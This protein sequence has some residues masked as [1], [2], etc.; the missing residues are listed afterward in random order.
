[1]V[2][3][4]YQRRGMCWRVCTVSLLLSSIPHDGLGRISE[5]DLQACVHGITSPSTQMRVVAYLTC[6][7]GNGGVSSGAPL[8]N[9]MEWV[10]YDFIDCSMV[11]L[12]M[13]H[14]QMFI[15]DHLVLGIWWAV[16]GRPSRRSPGNLARN[17]RYLYIYFCYTFFKFW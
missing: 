4:S 1:M 16:S 15:C 14:V 7:G 13:A 5:R 11:V 17:N 6:E 9:F 12:E 10:H 2:L 8:E 3:G